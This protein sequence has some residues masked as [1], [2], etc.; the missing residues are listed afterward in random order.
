[1]VLL[2]HGGY[3]SADRA[4]KFTGMN[5]IA[6]RE[7]FIVIYPDATSDRHWRDGRKID[8]P[9][10]DDVGFVSALIPHVAQIRNIDLRRIYAAG[11]SNGGAFTARL[12][13]ELSDQIA[14][15]AQVVSTMAEELKEHCRTSRPV[16]IMIIN[17]TEDPLVP[18]KDGERVINERF[19]KGGNFLT[20]LEVVEFWVRKNECNSTLAV[21]RLGE[22]GSAGSQVVKFHYRNDAADV[23]VIHLVIEGGGHS[24]PG[25]TK[26]RLN[27]RDAGNANMEINASEEIWN[28]FNQYALP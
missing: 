19:G 11:F 10:V 9:D 8:E 6:E 2:F 16:P 12:A 21:K 26:S 3:G 25:A 18:W 17:G 20:V 27:K 22:D 7:G 28:F 4:A 1:M 14:A 13:C 5:A 23:D 24:W 15:F